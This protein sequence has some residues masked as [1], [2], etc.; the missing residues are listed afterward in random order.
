MTATAAEQ[1][2]LLID[3]EEIKEL[4]ARYARLVHEG[5]GQGVGALYTTDARFKAGSAL[6]EGRENLQQFLSK[7]LSPGKSTPLVVNHILDIQADQARG[8]CVMYTPWYRHE[9]P[10][11]CG[12]YHDTYRKVAGRWYF[13]ERDFTFHEGKPQEV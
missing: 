3:R 2:Q 12:E 1:L 10:G 11:F 6:V 13:V 9:T 4:T 5:D 8:Y 7:T